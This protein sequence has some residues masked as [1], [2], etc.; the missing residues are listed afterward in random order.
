MKKVTLA[1][2]VL[3]S[4][5]L[6]ACSS[7]QNDNAYNG[8][9]LFSSYEGNNLKLTVRKND[10]KRPDGPL[11]D[12]VVSHSYDSHLVV[13]ACVR[14]SSDENGTSVTNISRKRSSSWLSRTS[15]N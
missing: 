15:K 12:I 3:L 2:T 11:E 13:G 4:L 9:I 8:E 6:A 1:L 7:N 14:V 10:C 5:G